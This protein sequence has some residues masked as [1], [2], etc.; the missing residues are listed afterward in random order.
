M[1]VIINSIITSSPGILGIFEGKIR[2]KKN[3]VK[4]KISG[5]I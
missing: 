2:R 5:V 3:N 1:I 4:L